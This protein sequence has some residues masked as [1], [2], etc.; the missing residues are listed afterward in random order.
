MKRRKF[1]AARVEDEDDRTSAGPRPQ[2]RSIPS[3]AR[4]ST[5]SAGPDMVQIH[6]EDNMND[7]GEEE[8]I[9]DEDDDELLEQRD[10]GVSQGGGIDLDSEVR[11]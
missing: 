2:A 7:S 3:Q 8:V 1:A 5:R 9:E 10:I 11:S 4:T 6:Y